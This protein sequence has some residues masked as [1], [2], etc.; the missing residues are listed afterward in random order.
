VR[1]ALVTGGG[2][3]IGAAVAT[4]LAAGGAVV[5]VLDRDGEAARAVA[6][7]IGERGGAADAVEADVSDVDTLAAE[8]AGVVERHER[9]DYACNSAGVTGIEAQLDEYPERVFRRVL[10]VNATGVFACMRAE[11]GVM[12]RQGSGSIV[13][14]GSGA[15]SLG[16]AGHAAYVASK[17]AVAGLT[18][19]AAVEVARRN[20]QVNAVAPGLVDTGMAAG[21]DERAF[22]AEHPVGRAATAGE[23]AEVVAW[24]LESAPATLTG[25]IIPVDGGLTAKVAGLG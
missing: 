4:R 6:A 20:V 19:T 22:A 10:D 8:V 21:V 23:V 3:G 14:I 17:H 7:E 18:R 5:V 1:V 16:V 11:L 24:L 13:N 9:L 2:S 12:L 25:A 15:S